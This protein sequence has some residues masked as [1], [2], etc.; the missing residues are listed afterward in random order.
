MARIVIRFQ[1]SRECADLLAVLVADISGVYTE[2]QLIADGDI[3]I[4]LDISRL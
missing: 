2:F 4:N 3:I 1:I